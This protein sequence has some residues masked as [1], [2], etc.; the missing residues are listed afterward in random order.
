[1]NKK[2]IVS[3]MRPT[4]RLHL[5][6]LH[7]ALNN[8]RSLQNE[9]NCFYF[10]AD[11]HAL[12]SEYEHTEII[13]VST[14]SIIIDWIAIGLDPKKS[15]FFVQSSIKEHAELHLIF[16]M[17]T[18]LSWLERNP[19]YKEQLTEISQKNLYTYGFLGY[20]VLQA[21]DILMYKANGVPVGE[22]QSPHVELTREIARRF[23]YFYSNIFPLPDTLLTTEAKILGIDRRK[24]SKGYANAI[25]ISDEKDMVSQKV[26]NMIT[27][28]QRAR[29]S[30]P[31]RPDFC[32]VF[33]FHELYSDEETVKE[34][35][36]K[37]QKA[38]IGCVECKKKMAANLNE[39]LDPIREKIRALESNP[40]IIDNIID[41]GNAKARKIAKNT[42]QEVRE[43]VKI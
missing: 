43:V 18:P 41:E 22:D 36:E 1:M 30:D 42:M 7:G 24:M 2:R 28:P 38:S 34:I 26:A 12:T 21:A 13:K 31:G 14:R 19:T 32:N 5:G 40:K 3:G 20:P 29:K 4:G 23:N 10:I 6:H 39:A 27:D 9:Y 8:W 25:F 17:V 16:S 37:C 33:T 35:A 11:W 15:V